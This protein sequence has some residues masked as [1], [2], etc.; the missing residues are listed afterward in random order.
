MID[1]TLECEHKSSHTLHSSD[2]NVRIC[3]LQTSH[4][5]A[6]CCNLHHKP[7]VASFTI[8]PLIAMMKRNQKIEKHRPTNAFQI[9]LLFVLFWFWCLI[10]A[11][12]LERRRRLFPCVDHCLQLVPSGVIELLQHCLQLGLVSIHLLQHAL[13]LLN[14]GVGV[15][16]VLLRRWKRIA[17]KRQG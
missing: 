5:T 13:Q 12:S 16:L 10:S 11:G 3:L 2:T 1:N 17:K 9:L 14:G 15:H 4:T 8:L 7:V 6:Y